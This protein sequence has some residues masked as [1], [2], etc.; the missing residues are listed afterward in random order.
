MSEDLFEG[1]RL[2]DLQVEPRQVTGSY[3]S[4]HPSPKAPT[5]SKITG[6]VET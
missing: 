1:F 4:R 5:A 2:R 3:G 6:R